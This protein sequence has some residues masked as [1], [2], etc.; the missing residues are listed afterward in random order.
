[1]CVKIVFVTLLTTT[2]GKNIPYNVDQGRVS[3]IVDESFGL[4]PSNVKPDP[5]FHHDHHRN[6][7]NHRRHDV[8]RDVQIPYMSSNEDSLNHLHRNGS[9]HNTNG[10][11]HSHRRISA[12]FA[13]KEQTKDNDK[14][15]HNQR[16]INA[17]SLVNTDRSDSN[18][19]KITYINDSANRSSHESNLHNRNDSHNHSVK[20]NRSNF[21]VSKKDGI[22]SNNTSR[23]TNNPANVTRKL[24]ENPDTAI[25]DNSSLNDS[26]NTTNTFLNTNRRFIDTTKNSMTQNRS[27]S[28]PNN[29]NREVASRNKNIDQVSTADAKSTIDNE[30]K[31]Q[32]TTKIPL[33]LH[34]G[35]DD[36]WIWADGESTKTTTAATTTLAAV[37]LDDRAAFD[38]SNCPK[39]QAKIGN[40]VKMNF[41]VLLLVAFVL[42]MARS[43]PSAAGGPLMRF[44]VLFLVS[45][46]VF[47][48]SI[49]SAAGCVLKRDPPQDNGSWALPVTFGE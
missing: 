5:E 39:G 45:R 17:T 4:R 36:M 49:P 38:G 10:H 47:T 35:R 18:D 21:N 30:V 48:G 46:D 42:T 33:S 24:L 25:Y 1:M 12:G 13:N 11:T 20:N 40:T 29:T 23:S 2:L 15:I 16:T 9:F 43:I 41:R 22:L 28:T 32:T 19:K 6:I 3:Q 8:Q 27:I 31:Q 37:D 7:E 44:P 26:K 34:T 14:P